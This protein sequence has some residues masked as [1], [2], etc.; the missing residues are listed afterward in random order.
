MI[1]EKFTDIQEIFDVEKHKLLKYCVVRFVSIYPVVE[2][3]VEQINPVKKLFLDEIPKNYPKVKLQPK[4][5]RIRKALKDPFTFPTLHFLQFVLKNFH[6]YEKLFQRKEPT[7][8]L[9]YDKQVYLFRGMLIHF[10]VFSK[11][12]PLKSSVELV[13]FEYNNIDNIKPLHEISIGIKAKKLISHFSEQ[14]KVLFLTGVKR[15]FIKICD[16]MLSKLSLNNKF[17]S[18]LRFL[19]PENITQEGLKMVTYIAKSMPPVVKLSTE[20]LDTLLNGNF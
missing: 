11:I 3:L 2:R 1:L 19:N 4:V 8:H 15:F 14:V 20:D 6:K 17:L 12:K 9:L 7:I 18:N 5:I 16:E 10:C 13:K